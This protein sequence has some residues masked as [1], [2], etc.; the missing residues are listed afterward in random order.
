[1]HR[2]IEEIPVYLLV[3][4]FLVFL[5]RVNEYDYYSVSVDLKVLGK[6]NFLVCGIVLGSYKKLFESVS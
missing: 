1:M 5:M 4:C 2:S 3:D 6:S